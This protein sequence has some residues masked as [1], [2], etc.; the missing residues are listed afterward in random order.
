[1]NAA[2]ALALVAAGGAA[3]ALGRSWLAPWVAR[4]VTEGVYGTLAVNLV[5][6]FLLGVV[7]EVGGEAAILLLGAGLAGALTTFSTFAADLDMLR[8]ER[9]WRG[10]G[11]YAAVSVLGSVGAVVAGAW[12]AAAI[13]G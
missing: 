8:A 10:L 7:I 12:A 2:G 13:A 3:G 5:G 11:L 6:S 1:V 4:R 9:R